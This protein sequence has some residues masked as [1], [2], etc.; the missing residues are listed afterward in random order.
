VAQDL[1]LLASAGFDETVRVWQRQGNQLQLTATFQVPGVKALKFTPDGT[2]LVT[3]G[4]TRTLKVWH[5]AS[6]RALFDIRAR[7]AVITGVTVSPDGQ[8][9]AAVGTDQT[10]RLLRLQPPQEARTLPPRPYSPTFALSPSGSLFAAASD[11]KSLLVREILTGK[12]VCRLPQT[13]GPVMHSTFSPD[14]RL[15][16]GVT[17]DRQVLVWDVRTARLRFTLEDRQTPAAES[18]KTKGQT[19]LPTARA[20]TGPAKTIAPRVGLSPAWARIASSQ[21][22][23]RHWLGFSPDSQ[24]LAVRYRDGT[25]KLWDSSGREK[26]RF[27]SQTH[28]MYDLLVFGPDGRSLAGLAENH[29]FKVWEARSGK[30]WWSVS[31][32]RQATFT[33]VSLSPSGNLLALGCT[34]GSIRLH[35]YVTGLEVGAL[36]G[37]AG[38][39][40]ALAFS[41]D[42]RRLASAG[43]DRT[44]KIW[45]VPTRRELLSFSGEGTRLQFTADGGRLITVATGAQTIKVWDGRPLTAAQALRDRGKGRAP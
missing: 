37:H 36:V 19:T 6:G 22:L 10:V 2:R 9:L 45:D 42:G 12:E 44:V 40:W 11:W 7:L 38:N 29:T 14:G 17:D 20:P 16:A 43:A 30:E 3:L 31:P 23:S 32:P 8:R 5:V 13:A 15:L 34:N 4:G 26:A 18:Q 39:V 35:Q 25:I 1:R 21:L 27:R 41:P 24:T 28:T 33:S